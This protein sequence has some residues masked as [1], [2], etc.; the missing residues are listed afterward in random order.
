MG[1]ARGVRVSSRKTFWCM[2]MIVNFDSY[3]KAREIKLAQ[4][5]F[6]AKV[7]AGKF[8]EVKNKPFPEDLQWEA[9]VD[10]LRGRVKVCALCCQLICGG[11]SSWRIGA[12]SLLRDRGLGRCG[13]GA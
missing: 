12:N 3:N 5:G 13:S 2:L 6:C 10:V 9:L 1:L 4:D 8:D 7:E 11:C